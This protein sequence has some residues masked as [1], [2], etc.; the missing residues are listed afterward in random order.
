MLTLEK[1]LLAKLDRVTL[2]GRGQV[3]GSAPGPR[4]SAHHGSSPEFADFRSYVE[5]DDLRRVD[6]NAYGR[7]DQLFIRLHAGEEMGT[8]SLL[9]DRSGSMHMGQPRKSQTVATIA[10]ALVYVGLKSHD[11]VAV[12]GWTDRIDRLVPPQ[13]GLRSLQLLWDR[14]EEI[15]SPPGGRTNFAALASFRP[16]GQGTVVVMSDF[17][18]ESSVQRG[19]EALAARGDRIVAIQVLAP[20]EL[21]PAF[22]GDWQ[23]VDVESDGAVDVTVAPRSVRRYL[24]NLAAHTAELQRICRHTGIAFVRFSSDAPLGSELLP[25][26]LGAGVIQ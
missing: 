26:L 3:A 24:A 22:S 23:L 1:D 17:L 4:R 13:A 8:L 12:A 6:W 2:T 7:L 21:H 5:G 20:E 11:R 9:L 10:A 19:L 14:I 16:P 18:S 15:L 25:A